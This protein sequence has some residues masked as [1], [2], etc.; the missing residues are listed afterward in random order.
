MQTEWEKRFGRSYYH[1]IYR[2]AL[3][4]V[5][6]SEDSIPSHFGRRQIQYVSQVLQE[7]R[8]VHWTLVFFHKPLWL[9]EEDTGWRKIEELL[10]SRNY[11]VFV[12]HLHRYN[13]YR[14]GNHS[15][16]QLATTGGKSDLSGIEAGRFD[17]VAWV[18]VGSDS[19]R[20]ALLKLDGILEDNIRMRDPSSNY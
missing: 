20:V 12:G 16:Y 14:R 1:F 11:T 7:N 8:K 10:S 17:Q 5:L 9:K 18:T 15:Y 4:M 19:P 3:F 6:S 2:N 13:K